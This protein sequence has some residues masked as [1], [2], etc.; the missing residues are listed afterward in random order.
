MQDLPKGLLDGV[1]TKAKIRSGKTVEGESPTIVSF[2]DS[3]Y[4]IL[5]ADLHPSISI[6]RFL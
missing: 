3:F 5:E 2:I 4:F 6:F 1:I